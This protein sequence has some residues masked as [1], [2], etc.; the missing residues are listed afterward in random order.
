[1]RSRPFTGMAPRRR[2]CGY[3][4]PSWILI[5]SDRRSP[6]S[7]PWLLRTCSAIA[8]FMSSPPMRSDVEWTMP[9]SE[10]T[11]TSVVPPPMSTT[12]FAPGSVMGRP[13]PTAA[14]TGS[15]TR[16]TLRAPACMAD[17]CT[18]RR[19]TW[20]MPEGTL[21]T[22]RG[23]TALRARWVLRMKYS[24]H[25]FG[26][27]VVGDD[28]VAERPDRPRSSPGPG[29]AWPWPVRR[30]RGGPAAGVHRDD[31]GLVQHDPL[32]RHEDRVLAVPRSTAMS[33][34]KIRPSSPRFMCSRPSRC[35]ARLQERTTIGANKINGYEMDSGRTVTV[36]VSPCRPLISAL[37]PGR[38]MAL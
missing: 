11:A 13:A 30:R 17:S 19:S 2:G 35:A 14:A 25:L 1:M 16:Y 23:C 10:I 32:A 34:E 21:I 20:V 22:T 9:E 24:E 15:D 18:A 7:R 31:R 28:A 33:L 29:R 5:S 27:I 4:E 38:S 8:S 3:A 12:M 37:T 36:P 6:I 26:R